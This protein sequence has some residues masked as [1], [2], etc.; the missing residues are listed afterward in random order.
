MES[1]HFD[2]TNTRINFDIWFAKKIT[3]CL[4]RY[5]N[6]LSAHSMLG[7]INTVHNVKDV[8]FEIISMVVLFFNIVETYVYCK[9]FILKTLV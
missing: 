8:N 2:S 7:V 3:N 1:F 4:S 6:T 5:E 9:Y